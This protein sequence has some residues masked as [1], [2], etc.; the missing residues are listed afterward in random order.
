[1][2]CSLLSMVCIAGGV[3]IGP[4]QYK[5][6]LLDTLDGV[7]YE[8]IMPTEEKFNFLGRLNFDIIL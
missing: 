2:L 1:M 3:E 5:V 6:E 7:I 4:N 8:V